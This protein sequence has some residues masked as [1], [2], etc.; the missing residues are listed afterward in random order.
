VFNS[1]TKS[2]CP[3]LAV[4]ILLQALLNFRITYSP[5]SMRHQGTFSLL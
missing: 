3:V 4:L 5:P 1:L 2:E